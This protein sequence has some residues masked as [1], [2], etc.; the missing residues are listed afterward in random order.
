M[1]GQTTPYQFPFG[2]PVRT[3]EQQDRSP[4]KA[5]VLGVYASAVHARWKGPDGKTRINALAVAS[6]PEIFWTGEKAAIKPGEIISR[7]RIPQGAGTLEP[8]SVKFNG[9][10]GIALD[11]LYLK[12]LGLNRSDVWLCDCVAHSCMNPAQRNAVKR[13]Y[14]TFQDVSLPTH[15]MPP[16]PTRLP[17]G[18]RDEI[19]DELL[20]SKA[21]LLVLLGDRP[22]QWFLSTLPGGKKRLAD[23]VPNGDA[24]GRPHPFVIEGRRIEILPLAHP[25]QV[26]ALGARSR[27]WKEWHKAWK[28]SQIQKR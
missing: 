21:E 5:F 20:T 11:E 8:A 25:R 6:E 12:P 9:P 24:Y 10:S 26:A 17:T 2:Q 16:G 3:V 18:R 14:D 19:L 13:R 23:Y 22:L 4:K 7:I 1:H 28:E 15:N 27:D